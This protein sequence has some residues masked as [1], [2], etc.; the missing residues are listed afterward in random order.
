MTF[1]LDNQ[2][3]T[4]SVV[5]RTIERVPSPKSMIKTFR[6]AKNHSYSQ[7]N[8]VVNQRK[9]KRTKSKKRCM[10]IRR[11]ARSVT[12]SRSCIAVSSRGRRY[13]SGRTK[14]NKRRR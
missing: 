10:V 3:V 14:N 4:Q 1:K 8:K 12:F 5:A 9:A 13:P 6:R 11:Q 2:R 7:V